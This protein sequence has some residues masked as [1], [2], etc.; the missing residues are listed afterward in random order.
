MLLVSNEYE[1][2]DHESFYRLIPVQTLLTEVF[3][4]LLI[5]MLFHKPSFCRDVLTKLTIKMLFCT[6]YIKLR[7]NYILSE[8]NLVPKNFKLVSLSTGT[9]D[10][11]HAIDASERECG[12]LQKAERNED[13]SVYASDS[14][15][16]IVQA[17]VHIFFVFCDGRK[18]INFF[19]DPSL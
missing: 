13:N 4:P 1:K 6:S 7:I 2:S 8:K 12:D 9:K 5:F 10:F 15:R 17:A 3:I 14:L 16:Y 19:S 11:S 18:K